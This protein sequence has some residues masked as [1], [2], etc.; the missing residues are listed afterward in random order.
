MRH[1]HVETYPERGSG[2]PVV[3]FFFMTQKKYVLPKQ[4]LANNQSTMC[5]EIVV[6]RLGVT[7]GT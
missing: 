1:L 6:N 5:D 7:I 2:A 4:C 3:L